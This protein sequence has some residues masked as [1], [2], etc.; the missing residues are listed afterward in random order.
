MGAQQT[1]ALKEKYAPLIASDDPVIG[2]RKLEDIFFRDVLTDKAPPEAIR[3]TAIRIDEDGDVSLVCDTALKQFG[4]VVLLDGALKAKKGLS[5]TQMRALADVVRM[6]VRGTLVTSEA[7]DAAVARLRSKYVAVQTKE[8]GSRTVV[9]IQPPDKPC[10]YEP[11]SIKPGIFAE[12][13]GDL[14]LGAQTLPAE[15]DLSVLKFLFHLRLL[16][17]PA[18]EQRWIPL[19]MKEGEALA[20]L[21]TVCEPGDKLDP[22]RL[23]AVVAMMRIKY[24]FVSLER[25][26][27]ADLFI[28][29]IT[30]TR[31]ENPEPVPEILQAA[32]D[33]ERARN[34]M[35]QQQQQRNAGGDN[36]YPGVV[37]ESKIAESGQGVVFRG[38]VRCCS[39]QANCIL[40][41]F[42]ET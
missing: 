4:F 21:L 37:I 25:K 1:K 13:E 9:M 28:I 32:L 8:M 33:A 24:N 31:V 14:L 7:F 22:V 12:A 40:I 34:K 20:D 30:P 2:D 36:L 10:K 6:T 41:S 35:S 3:R 23:L 11:T 5:W 19:S 17:A 29:K 26:E 15:D 16:V 27:E 42:F 18:D 39:S 38:Q